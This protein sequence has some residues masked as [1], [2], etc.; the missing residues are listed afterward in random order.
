M[1]AAPNTVYAN[2][3]NVR[4]TT[5]ELILE[6]G[7]VLPEVGTQHSVK[8]DPTIRVVLSIQAARPFA[9]HL[10]KAAQAQEE[11]SQATGNVNEGNQAAQG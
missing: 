1:Q 7:F 11:I 10:I 5:S 8:F 9:E 2:I 3:V 6:F 4:A